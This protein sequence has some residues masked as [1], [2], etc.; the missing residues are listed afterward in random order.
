MT[1]HMR[2]RL[3]TWV[4]LTMR[5]TLSPPSYQ[6]RHRCRSP[7]EVKPS[8]AAPRA[9]IREL[10]LPAVACRTDVL[11]IHAMS[12]RRNGFAT[13]MPARLLGH[14]A[15]LGTRAA[16]AG[17]RAPGA[18]VDTARARGRPIDRPSAQYRRVHRRCGTL[19][20]CGG[21]GAPACRG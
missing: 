17:A 10:Q 5:T 15:D 8:L 13:V 21:P 4:L 20:G 18:C 16:D 7:A 3:F 19:A 11:G 12:Q 6:P 2:G 14:V 9:A 1:T